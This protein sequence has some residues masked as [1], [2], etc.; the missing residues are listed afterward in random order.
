MVSDFPIS[1][2]EVVDLLGLERSPKARSGASSFDVRCPICDDPGYHMNISVTKNAYHCVRCMDDTCKGTGVLDLYGRVALKTEM[3]SE[4]KE[5]LF[6]VLAAALGRRDLL[7]KQRPFLH[8]KGSGTVFTDIAPASDE[9]LNAVY[10]ALL[11]LPY[12]KLIDSHRDNLKRRGLLDEEIDANGYASMRTGLE[13]VREL[14]SDERIDAERQKALCAY[15]EQKE[16]YQLRRSYPRL[17]TYT[18]SDIMLGMRIAMD[19]MRITG[20]SPDHVP[21]FYKLGDDWAFRSVDPGILI[22]T[23]NEKGQIVGLQTRR[24]V[25]AA[26]GLRY[27][28]VSS[29]DLP[30]GVTTGIA[31]T[32]FPLSEQIS[33]ATTV[34]LTEG[35][36]KADVARSLFRRLGYTDIALIALQG[37]NSTRELPSIGRNLSERGIHEIK[38]GFDMDKFVNPQVFRAM[39]T[40]Q[41]LL[42]ENGKIILTPLLW[43]RTYAERKRTQMINLCR[44]SDIR[45]ET[46]GNLY[47]DLVS[48]AAVLEKNHI[49]FAYMDEGGMRIEG[50]WNDKTKG[51]DDYLLSVLEDRKTARES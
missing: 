25:A 8:R 46:T 47:G 10:S 12:L 51:I 40:A 7:K 18:D 24:D 30:E 31:R 11:S 44:S 43:D 26:K 32:H 41:R 35:P 16:L 1:I 14:K 9:K 20:M 49:N 27:M 6:N 33:A 50:K 28:T 3:T 29:K 2:V 38:D 17:V 23:R 5:M 22:P 42:S 36:L 48:L 13:L 19:V 21:G 34:I 45:W 37:V 39:K 4:N 15:Y